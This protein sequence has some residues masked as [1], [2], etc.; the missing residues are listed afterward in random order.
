MTYLLPPLWM[1]EPND[2]ETIT[3]GH[4][5]VIGFVFVLLLLAALGVWVWRE[6]RQPRRD[7]EAS[8]AADAAADRALKSWAE[9]KEGVCRSLD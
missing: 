6:S 3:F 1:A 9:N 8:D 7:I 4:G 2:A 5:I